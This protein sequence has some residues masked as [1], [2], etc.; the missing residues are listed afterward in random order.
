VGGVE[1]N[2]ANGFEQVKPNHLSVSGSGSG[3]DDC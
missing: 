2:E 1:S 3:D